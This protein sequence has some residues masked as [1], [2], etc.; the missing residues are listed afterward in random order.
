MKMLQLV[1]GNQALTIM[2]HYCSL[3]IDI[4]ATAELRVTFPCFSRSSSPQAAQDNVMKKGQITHEMGSI[5][6]CWILFTCLM[7]SH[8]EGCLPVPQRI[9]IHIFPVSCGVAKME[10]THG[11]RP[12]RTT[13]LLSHNPHGLGH[14]SDTKKLAPTCTCSRYISRLTA[15]KAESKIFGWTNL[16]LFSIDFPGI[17]WG[18]YPGPNEEILRVGRL[19]LLQGSPFQS[20]FLT[21]FG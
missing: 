3:D 10:K 9:Y 17:F 13:C 18:P 11:F 12:V 1:S 5:Q 14:C 21:N 6:A 4:I 7:C 15:W 2:A 20:I 8:A 19:L 16:R